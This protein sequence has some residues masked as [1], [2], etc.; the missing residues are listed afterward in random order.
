MRPLVISATVR[1]EVSLKEPVHLDGLLAAAVVYRDDIPP[2]Y[3]KEELVPIEIP[4]GREPNGR[5]HFASASLSAVE[6]TVKRKT[7][8][9]FPLEELKDM[10][11]RKGKI[12]LSA[13]RT[14]N[15]C[16]PRPSCH[17]VDDRMTWYAVGNAEAVR[18]LLVWVTHIGK[19]R[20]VGYGA[21][22]SWEVREETEPPW[23]GFPVIDP[24]GMPLR[25][26]PRDWPGVNHDARRRIGRLTFPYWLK[27]GTEELL[28]PE[29]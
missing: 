4:V 19:H 1:G 23:D 16:I 29:A 17:L 7:I 26:L 10:G 6:V 18:E 28:C 22:E 12:N 8:K 5:F 20:A 3:T 2:A 9:R 11:V 14:K 24:H 15:Y 13:G 25:N 27:T 21:V